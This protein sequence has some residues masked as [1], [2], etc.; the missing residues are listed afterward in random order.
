MNSIVADA[1]ALLAVACREDGCEAVLAVR[2]RII[3]SAANHAEVVSGLLRCDLPR[4]DIDRFLH[5]AFPNVVA[6]DR[7]Q[8]EIAGRLHAVTRGKKIS[9]A[10]CAC[11]ALAQSRNLPVLT[12]DRKWQEL[13]LSLEIQLFR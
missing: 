11:L 9:Y 5:D 1:S 12:G 10:D 13:G 4:P 7:E 6:F 3:V 2:E 8:A